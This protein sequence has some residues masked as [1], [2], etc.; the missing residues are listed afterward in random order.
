MHFALR[1]Y[2]S[3]CSH[4]YGIRILNEDSDEIMKY[5][6]ILKEKGLISNVDKYSINR[7][8]LISLLKTLRKKSVSEKI[9]T[10]NTD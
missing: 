7:F 5:S 4:L 9:S 3:L 2:K 10:I 8:A 1:D 6:Q